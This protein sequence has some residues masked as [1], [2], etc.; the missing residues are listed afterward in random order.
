MEEIY[1]ETY[2]FIINFIKKNEYPST[3][4][5]IS[6]GLGYTLSA[7]ARRIHKLVDLGKIEIKDKSPRSIK[8]VGY[9]FVVES[10]DKIRSVK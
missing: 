2:M 10:E 1:Y 5:E 8:V 6:D 3:Y 4:R 7:I 9:Q